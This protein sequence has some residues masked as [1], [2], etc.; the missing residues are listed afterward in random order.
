MNQANW[1]MTEGESPSERRSSQST[2]PREPCACTCKGAGEASAA[3]RA[4]RAMERRKRR[5]LECRDSVFGRRQHRSSQYGEDRPGSTASKNSGTYIRHIPG[6][7]RSSG[8][9]GGSSPGPRR[10]IDASR[11]VPVKVNAKGEVVV[12]GQLRRHQGEL[13]VLCHSA[14]RAAKDHAIRQRFE[15]RFEQ[16]ADKLTARVAGGRLKKPE[17]INQAIGRLLGRYGRVARYYT[18]QMHT[19]EK[20]Q[21]EV[22]W[23]KKDAAQQ[24]AEELDGTYLLRTDRTDLTEAD[25]WKL[26]VLLAR[27][28]RSFRYLKSNLG[29]RPVFHQRTERAD[30]H[31]LKEGRQTARLGKLGWGSGSGSRWASVRG[32]PCR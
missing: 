17:K 6:P 25:L 9:P 18:V 32:R 2:F 20:G 23:A 21:A 22:R 4:G 7:G 29:L 8:R 10:E 12:S 15:R 28:E 26:Y 11:Y 31:I 3:V 19:D 30:A 27:I 5:H 16:D 13:Y 24:L 14:A 1:H